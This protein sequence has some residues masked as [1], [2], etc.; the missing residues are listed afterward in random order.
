MSVTKN[1]LYGFFPYKNDVAA[2]TK[3]YRSWHLFAK[4]SNEQAEYTWPVYNTAPYEPA[5]FVLQ[6][7]MI[8]TKNN[9][10]VV[11]HATTCW[12]QVGAKARHVKDIVKD[13]V[14]GHHLPQ[15]EC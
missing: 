15:E 13:N 10:Y 12:K 8:V 3:I 7:N 4:P 11:L 1:F 2:H 5:V 9:I 6:H 14:H